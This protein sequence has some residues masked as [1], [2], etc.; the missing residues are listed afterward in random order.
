VAGFLIRAGSIKL[1]VFLTGAAVVS[2]NEAVP[3]AGSATVQVVQAAPV[4]DGFVLLT[5]P[6]F[7]MRIVSTELGVF[8]GVVPVVPTAS[9]AVPVVLQV[10]QA[11]PV[12]A[13][14]DRFTEPG[15]LM[16]PASPKIGFLMGFVPVLAAPVDGSAT[17][18]PP[19][20]FIVVPEV[21][22]TAPAAVPVVLQV[23][24]GVPVDAGSDGIAEPGFLMR[25]ASPSK[26]GFLG[27]IAPDVPAVTVAGSAAVHVAPVQACPDG[28]DGL[29]ADEPGFL[30]RPASVQL[31]V[32]MG[33]VLP[34]VPA[35]VAVQVV[36]AAPVN[37]SADAPP[38]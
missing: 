37:G 7:L 14:S 6:E 28:L 19:V 25:P 13:G 1:I 31:G 15:I 27:G 26:L 10:V 24:Q 2:T 9:V 33:A 29:I 20:L 32:F 4:A 12:D 17:D 3:V 16:R 11:V 38:V 36:Q 21:V 23:V 30:M 8:T 18:E 22:P 35:A 34:A 5:E